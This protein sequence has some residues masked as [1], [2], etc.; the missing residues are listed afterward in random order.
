MAAS[1]VTKKVATD[2]F[3][4]WIKRCPWRIMPFS[5]LKHVTICLSIYYLFIYQFVYCST[6]FSTFSIYLFIYLS[7]SIYPSMWH[8]EY[9]VYIYICIYHIPCYMFTILE[10]HSHWQ[11]RIC[12]HYIIYNYIYRQM[13]FFFASTHYWVEILMFAYVWILLDL[14]WAS[15]GKVPLSILCFAQLLLESFSLFFDHGSMWL[16]LDTSRHTVE[17]CGAIRCFSLFECN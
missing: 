16:L 3:I 10:Y 2:N 7:I 1:V 9:Y 12:A 5:L 6:Y 4:Y 13:F 11:S 15:Q 8:Y 17:I 14:F